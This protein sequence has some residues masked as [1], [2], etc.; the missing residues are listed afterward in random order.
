MNVFENRIKKIENERKEL[1]Y[2]RKKLAE[3]QEKKRL[4]HD[5][6]ITGFSLCITPKTGIEK[7]A[8]KFYLT[9]VVSGFRRNPLT[10]LPNLRAMVS[11]R[12]MTKSAVSFT[13]FGFES[14]SPIREEENMI[15]PLK[16]CH[17]L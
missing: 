12:S 13:T 5:D 2:N 10:V 17:S 7:I 4:S 3:L 1:E 11:R 15:L 6:C 9:E 16:M 8:C 14:F